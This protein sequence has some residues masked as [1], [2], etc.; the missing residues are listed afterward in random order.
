M[1]S[2]TPVIF[3]EESVIN[4]T[5]TLLPANN[6]SKFCAITFKLPLALLMTDELILVALLRTT[7]SFNVI[8]FLSFEP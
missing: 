7:T 5:P 8:S 4:V 1:P 3:P 6:T 2:S